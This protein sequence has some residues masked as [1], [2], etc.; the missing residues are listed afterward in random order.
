MN[1][2]FAYMGMRHAWGEDVPF[3]LNTDDRRHHAYVVGKTGSG[4]TTLLRNMII[5]DIA[6]GRGV[7]V[8]DPHGDLAHELLDYIPPWRTDDVVYFDPSDFDFPIGLN[9]VGGHAS[10]RAAS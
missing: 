1:K 3:G 8:I 2:D 4:K 7:G 5:Q 9:L 10:R 6:A